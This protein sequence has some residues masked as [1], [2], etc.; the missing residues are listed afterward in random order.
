MSSQVTI[1]IGYI[2]FAISEIFPFLP[3]PASGLLHS[4]T[5]GLSNAFINPSQD[6]EMAQSLVSNT[7]LASIVNTISTSP[8]I[9]TIVTD[10]I[11]NQ[12]NANNISAVQSDPVISQLVSLTNS[13]Q[14]FKLQMAAIVKNPALLNSLNIAQA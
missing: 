3:I 1:I 9:K 5:L 13:N 11:N 7:S 12:S 6:I 2:L 4:L 10:L 14:Q 8:Q